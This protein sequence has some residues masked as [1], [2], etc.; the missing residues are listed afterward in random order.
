MTL[1]YNCP[2]LIQTMVGFGYKD[3]FGPANRQRVSIARAILRNPRILILDESY[4]CNG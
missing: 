2:T 3:L 1:S 4:R